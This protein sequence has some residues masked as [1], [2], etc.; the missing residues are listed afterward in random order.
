MVSILI[1]AR[2]AEATIARALQSVRSQTFAPIILADDHSTDRTV[3]V[4]CDLA[5]SQ[6]QVVRPDTRCT[7]AAVRQTALAR[8][9]RVR[10]K[11]F[12]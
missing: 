5:G 8:R 4:A 9:W 3:E 11:C 10:R 2:N 1:P 6:L 7:V 12:G